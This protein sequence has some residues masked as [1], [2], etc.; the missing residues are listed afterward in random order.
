MALFDVLFDIFTNDESQEAFQN[1]PE[2]FL[3]QNGLSNVTSQDIES[4]APRVFAAATGAN[5]SFAESGNVVLPPPPGG[6]SGGGFDGGDGGS[7]GLSGAIE[8]IN[9]YTNVFNETNQE[10]DDRD[11]TVDNSVNQ[12]IE[13]FGDVNQDFDTDIVSG[14]GAV[15]NEGDDAQIN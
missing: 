10:V 1:N 15:S 5:T 6:G 14:D 2:G 13:A 8:S 12:N 9:H 4:E 3:N 7:G 11:T